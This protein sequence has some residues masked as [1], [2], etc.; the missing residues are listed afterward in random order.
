MEK[1]VVQKVN[2]L[3]EKINSKFELARFKLFDIRINEGV[4]ECCVTMLDGSTELSNSERRG[5]VLLF[6][7]R[8]RD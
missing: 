1:F 6:E 2:M 7:A 3:E 5:D 4:R 8:R